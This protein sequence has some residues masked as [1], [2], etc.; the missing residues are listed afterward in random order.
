MVFIIRGVLIYYK[1]TFYMA[2]NEEHVPKKGNY[3]NTYSEGKQQKMQTAIR[4]RVLDKQKLFLEMYPKCDC[5]LTATCK[6]LGMVVSTVRQWKVDYPEF[7][8]KCDEAYITVV[9]KA[10]AQLQKLI[11]KGNPAAIMF[12]LKCK[13]G[14]KENAS[15]DINAQVTAKQLIL[16]VDPFASNQPKPEPKTIEDTI[17]I[18][19]IKDDSTNNVTE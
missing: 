16:N 13:G 18:D 5:N 14:Y 2:K 9:N 3:K 11:D 7:R 4:Q 15:L 8:K 19:P 10:E 12:F 17:E 6:V 1:R